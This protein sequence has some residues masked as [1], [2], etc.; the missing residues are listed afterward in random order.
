MRDAS[1]QGE[2]VPKAGEQP[3]PRGLRSPPQAPKTCPKRPRKIVSQ[4]LRAR[5]LHAWGQ[6][7]RMAEAG[8]ENKRPEQGGGRT[9]RDVR[10]GSEKG[11]QHEDFPGGRG[12]TR[13]PAAAPS[14]RSSPG[15]QQRLRA[16]A[17]PDK[18]R[19]AREAARAAMVHVSFYRNYGKMF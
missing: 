15:P 8:G 5:D 6:L 18:K 19:G 4:P 9:R 10:A 16:Q 7:A 14:S 3:P 13:L 12:F 1:R 17:E 11:V 2:L